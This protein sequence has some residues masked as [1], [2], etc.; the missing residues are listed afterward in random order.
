M[1]QRFAAPQFLLETSVLMANTERIDE[2]TWSIGICQD[3]L[4]QTKVFHFDLLNSTALQVGN[5]ITATE[6]KPDVELLI[7]FLRETLN[8][9]MIKWE[10]VFFRRDQK[11]RRWIS[12]KNRYNMQCDFLTLAGVV[13]ELIDDLNGIDTDNGK[14][15]PEASRNK[16][17]N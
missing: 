2:K 14:S 12:H 17:I 13:S 10:S 7:R 6:I 9:F 5:S 16:G 11:P 15:S 4:R 8:P 1:Q 3:V